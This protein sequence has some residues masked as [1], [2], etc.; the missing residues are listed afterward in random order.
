MISLRFL[1]IYK[2]PP[3]P[4]H[5]QLA[6]SQQWLLL[7]SPLLNYSELDLHIYTTT[8]YVISH[9]RTITTHVISLYTYLGGKKSSERVSKFTL[10]PSCLPP[11]IPKSTLSMLC[12]GQYFTA[13][14]LW[15]Y[16]T[17]SMPNP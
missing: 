12:P 11:F 16:R 3:V 17:F 14:G 1:H 2:T 7:L 13:M 5:P 15:S 8:F 4:P 6:P 9:L 10:F